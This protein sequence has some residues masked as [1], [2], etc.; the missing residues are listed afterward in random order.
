M[1]SLSRDQVVLEPKSAKTTEKK[2]LKT[3]NANGMPYNSIG[4]FTSTSSENMVSTKSP[5][6]PES[7]LT[8]QIS[9]NSTFVIDVE[10]FIRKIALRKIFER[11]SFVF[12]CADWCPIDRR[13][14]SDGGGFIGRD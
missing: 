1:I 14:C 3:P 13:S 5:S 2:D 4:K 10:P 8:S 9:F 11:C 6:D 7:A 12:W